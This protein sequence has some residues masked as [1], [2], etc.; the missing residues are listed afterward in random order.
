MTKMDHT[1]IRWWCGSLRS[2]FIDTKN[3]ND[4]P[5]KYRRAFRFLNGAHPGPRVTKPV[6]SG[7][8]S[9]DPQGTA[10]VIRYDGLTDQLT[11]VFHPLALSISTGGAAT[12]G[13]ARGMRVDDELA[14]LINRPNSYADGYNRYTHR[15]V[16]ELYRLNL[17]PFWAQ[18]PVGSIE[19]NLATALDLLCVDEKDPGGGL[20]NVQLKTGFEI[21]RNYISIARDSFLQSPYVKDAALATYGDSHAARHLL[22]VTAEHIIVQTAYGNP[23]SYS[24]LMVVSLNKTRSVQIPFRNQNENSEEFPMPPQPPPEEVFENLKKR[25]DEMEVETEVEAVRRRHALR[26]I[27]RRRG[28]RLIKK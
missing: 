2:I 16:Q 18:V 17:R 28:F 12:G 15:T 1:Q 9:P 19:L 25:T 27:R 3:E 13:S 22:Q 5:P 20:V 7:F 8:V 21:H 14:K 11:K 6:G 23:L 4:L 10:T 26:A 24:L